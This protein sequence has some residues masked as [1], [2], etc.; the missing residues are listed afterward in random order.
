MQCKLQ[1]IDV[2]SSHCQFRK[3]LE[4]GPCWDIAQTLEAMSKAFHFD[5]INSGQRADQFEVVK[6]PKCHCDGTMIYAHEYHALYKDLTEAIVLMDQRN[7]YHEG[8]I[9]RFFRD[10]R[11]RRPEGCEWCVCFAHKGKMAN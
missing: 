2:L 1:D 8:R 6:P 11:Y 4:D 5:R 9:S 10:N 7:P 3:W